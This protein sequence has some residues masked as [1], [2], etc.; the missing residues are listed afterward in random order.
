MKHAD[1]GC[2][3]GCEFLVEVAECKEPSSDCCSKTTAKFNSEGCTGIH[4]SVYTFAFCKICL[5]RAVGDHGVHVSLPWSHT[6]SCNCRECQHER[7]TVYICGNN[8]KTSSN[9]SN[10]I[11]LCVFLCILS[12]NKFKQ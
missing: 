9:G 10:R 7:N 5:F 3:L 12:L 8:H 2:R 4:S 1:T 11:F 6:E